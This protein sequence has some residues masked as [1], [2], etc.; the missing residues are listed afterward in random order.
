ML[1]KLYRRTTRNNHD[2]LDDNASA[3]ELSSSDKMGSGNNFSFSY[4]M[5]ELLLIIGVDW[6]RSLVW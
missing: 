1:Q 4:G 5:F 3:A 2:G 6:T